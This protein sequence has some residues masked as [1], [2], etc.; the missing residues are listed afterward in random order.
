MYNIDTIMQI[1]P[2]RYPFLL[3]DRVLEHETD[4]R[5][6]CLKNI[7]YGEEI[8]T[9]HFPDNA[10]Y[11]GVMLV[12]M[13]LQCTQVALTNIERFLRY[14]K[15]CPEKI[16]S[17]QGYVLQIDKFQFKNPA[18]AGDQLYIT[19]DITLCIENIGMS[20]CDMTIL[21]QDKTLVAKGSASVGWRKK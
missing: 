8:L 7:T 10:I 5:A 13:G 21:N 14:K 1:L 9:G 15:E 3:I 2:H 4:V 17:R 16:E 20:K 18:K 6:V 11:P 12:E 19:S